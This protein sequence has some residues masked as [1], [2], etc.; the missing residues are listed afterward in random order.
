MPDFIC[1]NGVVTFN[2]RNSLQSTELKVT[3]HLL[4]L[5]V[6]LMNVLSVTRVKSTVASINGNYNLVPFARHQTVLS[7]RNYPLFKLRL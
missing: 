1:L 6:L 5:V 7:F 3:S 2:L 4:Q